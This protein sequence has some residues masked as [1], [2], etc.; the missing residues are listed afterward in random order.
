MAHEHGIRG[1][2]SRF[3]I[4]VWL[5]DLTSPPPPSAGQQTGHSRQ[6]CD[7]APLTPRGQLHHH[8]RSSA[9][10]HTPSLLPLASPS[11][12]LQQ[13]TQHPPTSFTAPAISVADPR[14]KMT[15]SRPPPRLI[16]WLNEDVCD[17]HKEFPRHQLSQQIFMITSEL[18]QERT[19]EIPR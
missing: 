12:T 19:S 1:V 7:T 4:I 16:I 3:L 10:L 11:F 2:T 5:H 18:D 15:S 14:F 8:P 17:P 9:S 6:Q 13:A